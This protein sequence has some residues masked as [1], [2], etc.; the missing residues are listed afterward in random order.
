MNDVDEANMH[1]NNEQRVHCFCLCNSNTEKIPMWY[2]YSGISG[3]GASLGFTPATMIKFIKSID[4]VTTPDGDIILYKD[5]DFK[6]DYGWVF[7][8]K[9]KAS[10]KVMYKRKWYSLKDPEKF[11]R[12]NYFIKLYPWEYEKEFRIVI[13]NTTNQVYDQLVLDIEPIIEKLKIKLAPEIKVPHFKKMIPELTGFTN[14]YAKKTLPSSL[15]INM[16]LFERNI[17]GYL[18]YIKCDVEK[19]EEDRKVNIER[20][21]NVVIRNS[22]CNQCENEKCEFKRRITSN[23][24]I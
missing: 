3:Q 4:R 2:L 8:R 24:T 19:N 1:K 11:N 18:D 12:D 15:K 20:I 9:S 6:L 5:K 16:N 21:C 22:K 17:E 7:Y 14:Q 10:S 23:G 13:R